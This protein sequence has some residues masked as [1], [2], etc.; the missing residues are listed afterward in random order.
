MALSAADAM[1]NVSAFGCTR[2]H[3]GRRAAC[4]TRSLC[5][6]FLLNND[7]DGRIHLGA[8]SRGVGGGGGGG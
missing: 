2:L 6:K 3:D 4:T 5:L 8:P 7:N 1:K